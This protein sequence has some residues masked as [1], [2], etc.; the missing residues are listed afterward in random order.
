MAVRVT[1]RF[2]LVLKIRLLVPFT[3]LALLFLAKPYADA[4]DPS[5]QMWLQ[6]FLNKH[7][8]LRERQKAMWELAGESAK[9]IPFD[10]IETAVKDE[11]TSIRIHGLHALAQ[12]GPTDDQRTYVLLTECFRDRDSIIRGVA[13][14]TVASL[15]E[16]GR[17]LQK[18]VV[19]LLSDPAWL[20]TR[21]AI[22]ALG[23]MKI[24]DDPETIQKLKS[25][26]N[27]YPAK[28]VFGKIELREDAIRKHYLT[29]YNQVD[30]LYLACAIQRGMFRMYPKTAP[31]LAAL[32]KALASGNKDR[33]ETVFRALLYDP[34]PP[35]AGA[36]LISFLDDH[37]T[38]DQILQ[39][40]GCLTCDPQ[41]IIGEALVRFSQRQRDDRSLH[42]LTRIATVSDRALLYL[43]RMADKP[44]WAYEAK[45]TVAR[46]AKRV[47]GKGAFFIE[48]RQGNKTADFFPVM[49]DG[50]KSHVQHEEIAFLGNDMNIVLVGPTSKVKR[51]SVESQ[52]E[53]GIFK[54]TST[55]G[56]DGSQ[57]LLRGG[58]EYSKW[59]PN[60]RV[61]QFEF[62]VDLS[63]DK[64]PVPV[65]YSLRKRAQKN[66]DISPCRIR[67]RLRAYAL[68]GTLLFEKLIIYVISYGC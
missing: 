9:K 62:K 38:Q 41:E 18:E 61:S 11:N 24:I 17:P 2:E 40:L 52:Y 36:I 33:K 47:F 37:R 21:R 13:L 58:L 25:R 27:E 5:T 26:I 42:T 68:N 16:R 50:S 14:E 3:V 63:S 60:P 19:L 35:A 64:V 32:K 7:A 34:L 29:N 45:R 54:Y 59:L 31:I 65:A 67:Y 48:L 56:G 15:A 8:G 44:I 39:Y 49:G 23:A 66:S 10:V 6:T 30:D 28:E 12:R 57:T 55:P 4:Q 22:E 43:I 46:F 53:F 1:E 51:F 20:M